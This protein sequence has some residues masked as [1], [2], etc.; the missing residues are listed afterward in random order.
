[1]MI[2]NTARSLIVTLPLALCV[3]CMQQTKAN[4]IE[5]R[6]GPVQTFADGKRPS[7]ILHVD[8]GGNDDIGD[9]SLLKP[10]QSIAAAV[11]AAKPGTAVYIHAGT[12]R[13]GLSFGALR[14]SE[15]APIWLMGAPGEPRPVIRGGGQ[16]LHLIRPRYVV[17][18]DLEIRDIEDNG[19]NVD[20]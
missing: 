19:I 18:S 20:D 2:R 14:G 10:F 8:T 3:G 6:C 17:V 13:G 12:Y 9:G 16:G 4:V 15:S 1:M 5:R 11:R 7:D